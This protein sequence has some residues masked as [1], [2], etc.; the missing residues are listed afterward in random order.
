ME[1]W[2]VIMACA[3]VLFGCRKLPY[4]TMSMFSNIP[5]ILCQVGSTTA[6]ITQRLVLSDPDKQSK[7]RR[8][9]IPVLEEIP[10]MAHGCTCVQ[11]S[12]AGKASVRIASLHVSVVVRWYPSAFMDD[13]DPDV[14]EG[15]QGGR[16]TSFCLSI[17]LSA[18]WLQALSCSA[19]VV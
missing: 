5:W 7:L 8:L 12:M 14:F 4:S 2:F 13:Y 9:L 15:L 18:S 10:G 17:Q 11:A 3:C 1:S 19:I 6:N 16:L